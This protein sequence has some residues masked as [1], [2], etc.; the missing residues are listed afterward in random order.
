MNLQRS[1]V[2]AHRTNG[3]TLRHGAAAATEDGDSKVSIGPESIA[4]K[5]GKSIL[6]LNNDTIRITIE[7]GTGITIN[8]STVTIGSELTVQGNVVSN[9][10]TN[11]ETTVANNVNDV[12]QKLKEQDEYLKKLDTDMKAELKKYHDQV[13]KRRQSE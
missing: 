6:T 4:L 3:V 9:N 12:A 8:S 2:I 10:V 11:L 1:S 13:E 5:K 7:G